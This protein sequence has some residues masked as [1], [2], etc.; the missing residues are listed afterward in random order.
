METAIDIWLALILLLAA[1]SKAWRRDAATSALS[2]Y[3]LHGVRLQRAVLSLLIVV[4]LALAGC[5]AAQTVWAP[6]S[7]ACLFGLFS[8]ATLAALLAGRRD[9]PC[10]C[11]GGTSRLSW[12]TPVRGLALTL[13]SIVVALGWLPDAPSEYERW[14]TA[15]VALCL[16]AVVALGLLVLALA[17]EIGVLRLGSSSQGALEIAEEGPEH[18]AMQPWA[19]SLPWRP[20]A[21]LGLAIFTSE[22]C[23]LC[24]QLVPALRHV[25]ADPLLAVRS[26]DEIADAEVWRLG[27]VPGSPYAI[28]LGTDGVVAAKGTFNSLPQ[29]ESIIATA[30]ARQ[31]EVAGVT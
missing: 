10:A 13:M 5:L 3:G 28:A 27:S 18:G 19:V 12:W 8:L 7:A 1:G 15:A 21:L 16:A 6:A 30:R 29:L 20:S 4:E 23:P 22:G 14:L 31:R 24:R 26:F 2:T 17:R 25:A 11:F 9:R